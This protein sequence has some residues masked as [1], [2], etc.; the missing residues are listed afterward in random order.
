MKLYPILCTENLDIRT[1]TT[2]VDLTQTKPS[3]QTEERS[4]QCYRSGRGRFLN[5]LNW[6]QSKQKGSLDGTDTVD[7]SSTEPSVQETHKV[8]NIKQKMLKKNL[9]GFTILAQG[10]GQNCKNVGEACKSR[11]STEPQISKGHTRFSVRR[12]C[13]YGNNKA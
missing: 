3:S 4:H 13:I 10:H 8:V 11:H 9:V 12:L 1:D 7:S 6:K 5:H 2:T